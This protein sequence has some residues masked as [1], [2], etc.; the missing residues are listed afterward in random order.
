MP[1][2][3]CDGCGQGKQSETKVIHKTNSSSCFDKGVYL[4]IETILSKGKFPFHRHL[5][6]PLTMALPSDGVLPRHGFPVFQK[7][8]LQTHTRA[9]PRVPPF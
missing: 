9:F 1:K 2:Q 5:R 7:E 4:C 3:T 8:K 6:K